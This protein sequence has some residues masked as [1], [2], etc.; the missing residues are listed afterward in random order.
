MKFEYPQSKIHLNKKNLEFIFA[1]HDMLEIEVDLFA[2][3]QNSRK[4]S[5]WDEDYLNFLLIFKNLP[6][7][8]NGSIKLH[9]IASSTPDERKIDDRFIESLMYIKPDL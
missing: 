6:E 5:S 1:L 3:N 7:R 8:L 2:I 4:L 9:T